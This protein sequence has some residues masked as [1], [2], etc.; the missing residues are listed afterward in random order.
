METALKAALVRWL[1]TDTVLAGMVNAVE[2]E[3]PVAASP[4]T[5]AIVASASSDWSSKT[6]V[7]REVRIAFELVDRGDDPA[8]TAMIAARVEHRLATLAPQQDGLRVVMTQFL[9][10]RAERPARSLRAVLLEYRFLIF[11]TA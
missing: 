5:L 9:R 11:Q 10:S 2:E 3:A 4:P 6:S 8:T 1:R 7:G